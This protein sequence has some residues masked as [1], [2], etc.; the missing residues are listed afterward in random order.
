MII[1]FLASDIIILN[2]NR[3]YDDIKKI[4]I[5]IKSSLFKMKQANIPKVLRTILIQVDN[6]NDDELDIEKILNEMDSKLCDFDGIV[7][8]PVIIPVITKKELK[9]A[10]GNILDVLDYQISVKRTMAESLTPTGKLHF[11]EVILILI[12]ITN[13]L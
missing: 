8:K 13:R 5:M 3:R 9:N 7:L 10:G 6:E 4:L 1:S 11:M 2:S 12:K